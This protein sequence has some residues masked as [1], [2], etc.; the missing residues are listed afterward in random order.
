MDEQALEQESFLQCVAGLETLLI[1]V[2]ATGEIFEATADLVTP[3]GGRGA[4]VLGLLNWRGNLVWV[5][6][7]ASLL[8]QASSSVGRYVLVHSGA[9]QVALAVS[10]VDGVVAPTAGVRMIDPDWLVRPER[11]CEPA[12]LTY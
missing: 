2:Q 10:R 3:V 9:V 11:W 12:P 5:L 8:G 4:P 7:L 6:D 1:P